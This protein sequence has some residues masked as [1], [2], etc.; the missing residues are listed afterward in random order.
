LRKIIIILLAIVLLPLAVKA[1]EVDLGK[2]SLYDMDGQEVRLSDYKGKPV[3]LWFWTTWCPYCRRAIP[4]LNNIY[5]Q[6]KLEGIQLLAVNVDESREK[7]MKFTDSYPIDFDILQDKDGQCA[8]SFGVLGLPTYILID[9]E[10]NL[11]FKHN[12]FPNKAYKKLL[13]D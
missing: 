5:P 12:Y 4:E 10:G 11:R 9:R 3:V 8:Y 13:S 1:L 7:I 2:C 6:L